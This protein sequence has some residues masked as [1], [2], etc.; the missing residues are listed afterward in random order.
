MLTN[1]GD[2]PFFTPMALWVFVLPMLV[3]FKIPSAKKINHRFGLTE[4]KGPLGTYLQF[5]V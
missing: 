4:H 2:P 5:S 3:L 1:F